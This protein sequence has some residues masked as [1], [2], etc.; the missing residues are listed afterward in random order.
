MQSP[1]TQYLIFLSVQFVSENKACTGVT[2]AYLVNRDFTGH[3]LSRI[4]QCGKHLD[5]F[6]LINMPVRRNF[7][8]GGNGRMYDPYIERFLS[9]DNGACHANGVMQA[10]DNSQSFNRYSYCLNN[11]LVYTDPDGELFLPTL[12][13]MATG[14][15]SG[16]A[17][18]TIQ[19]LI[20]HNLTLENWNWGNFTGSVVAGGIAGVLGP[21]L[22]SYGIGVFNGGAILGSAAGVAYDSLQGSL[23]KKNSNQFYIS[24][25]ILLLQE[26]S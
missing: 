11:P 7:N 26:E 20:A 24:P 1:A 10:P 16:A 18:Y 17:S 8:E 15:V 5:R 13:W 2:S 23:T 9:P 14:M 12:L 4:K 25:L 3:S 6:G 22:S 21:A 19:H